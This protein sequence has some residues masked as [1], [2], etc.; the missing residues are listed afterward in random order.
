MEGRVSQ[1]LD[2][3]LSSVLKNQNVK[4]K[5]IHIKVTRFLT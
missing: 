3:Y 5:K 4:N 1:I 2:I